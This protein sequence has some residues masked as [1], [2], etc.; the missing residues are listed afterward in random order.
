MNWIIGHKRLI[1]GFSLIV[2]SVVW[3]TAAYQQT[4]NKDF[5][6]LAAQQTYLSSYANQFYDLEK[7]GGIAGMFA[8]AYGDTTQEGADSYKAKM[9]KYEGKSRNYTIAGFL[10]ITL[11]IALIAWQ[12]AIS[13]R[14]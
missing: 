3:F 11:G 8:K 2:V 1:I 10:S 9:A 13:K 6:T 4:H 5:E 14:K 7:E 12:I